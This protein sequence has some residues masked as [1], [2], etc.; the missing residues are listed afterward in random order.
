MSNAKDHVGRVNV[1]KEEFGWEIPVE[2]VPVPS[3]GLIYD[4][5]SSLYKKESVK[6]KAM[7][8]REED[9]LSSSALIKEGTVLDHLIDSCVLDDIDAKDM[10]LGDRNALMLAIRITGYGPEYPVR[11][12]CSSCN[13]ENKFSIDLSQIPIRRLTID[14]VEEGKNL[15]EYNLPVTKKK[16]LFKF[17][18]LRDDRERSFKEQS[19]KNH[20]KMMVESKI[21]GNLEVAIQQVDHVT[22]KN[23]IKHFIMN[24]PAFDSRSLRK[25]I[26]ENEPGMEMSCSFG[27]SNCG[28]Q[29]TSAIPIT[30]DFFWP[31]T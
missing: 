28:K 3:K 20:I 10:I 2:L 23:K 13:H 8:A 17:A 12:F 7:T 26:Q 1:M 5:E 9:I 24:M 22:D 4:A 27:C 19:L 6:I 11:A 14:P 18:T 15:F 31:S 16:V 21:T 30:S 25:F 29:N